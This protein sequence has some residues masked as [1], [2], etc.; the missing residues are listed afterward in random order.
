MNKFLLLLKIN[1]LSI[2]RG[3][4]SKKSKISHGFI[5][6]FVGLVLS[7]YSYKFAS[8]SMKG[9]K[10]INAQFILLPEFYAI[11]SLFLII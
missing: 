5:L 9:Y 7:Y 2:I 8:F 11:T 6:L 10:L 4:E 3:K 1:L